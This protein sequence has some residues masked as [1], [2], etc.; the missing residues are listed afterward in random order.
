MKHNK[1]MKYARS[2]LSMCPKV[3]LDHTHP[4]NL[5][6]N[7]ECHKDGG[8]FYSLKPQFGTLFRPCSS[9]GLG[10]VVPG[11]Q[12]QYL[13]N[14]LLESPKIMPPKWKNP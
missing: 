8:D 13:K 2:K 7:G 9:L 1:E 11:W 10:T 14:L 12:Q 6:K 3:L 5:R 4:S